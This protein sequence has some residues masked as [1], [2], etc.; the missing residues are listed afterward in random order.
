MT[1]TR[2]LWLDL[3]ILKGDVSSCKPGRI[4]GHEGVGAVNTVGSG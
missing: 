3:H 2:D 1:K 4:L